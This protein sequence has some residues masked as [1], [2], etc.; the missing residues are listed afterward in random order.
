M[1]NALEIHKK[2]NSLK[3]KLSKAASRSSFV[4]WINKTRLT[5]CDTPKDTHYSTFPDSPGIIDSEFEK[6]YPPEKNPPD[7]N[8]HNF[9]ATSP[10]SQVKDAHLTSS[11]LLVDL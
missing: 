8:V 10:K 7:T 4:I 5:Y 2:S 9:Q 3:K 6:M 11:I 1:C